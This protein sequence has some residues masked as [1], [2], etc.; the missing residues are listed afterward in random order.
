MTYHVN[1]RYMLLGFVLL[2]VD[3]RSGL[4]ALETNTDCDDDER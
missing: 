4:E 3:A 1:Q 2:G